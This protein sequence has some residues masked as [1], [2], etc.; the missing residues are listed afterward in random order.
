[1]PH[2]VERHSRVLVPLFLDFYR[3][4]YDAHV[5]EPSATTTSVTAVSDKKLVHGKLCQFLALFAQFQNPKS[6]YQAQTLLAIYH[7][8][9]Q[10]NHVKIQQLALQCINTW[11]LEH[12]VP[13]KE[14]LARLIDEASYREELAVLRFGAAQDMH[15]E[16]LVLPQHRAA[17][18][19][20]VIRIL[21][22]KLTAR[23]ARTGKVG[24]WSA[25]AALTCL[26]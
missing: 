2:V 11:K 6:T 10:R 19:P 17:L 25:S 22:P 20:L 14:H 1:M 16:G 26:I 3:R 15:V 5:T 4:Y 8:L 13:Y 24:D 21:Y 12:V 9:L 7:Q 18:A 23:K